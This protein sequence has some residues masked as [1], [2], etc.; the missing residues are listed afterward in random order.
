MS[1]GIRC[2]DAGAEIRKLAED[3]LSKRGFFSLPSPHHPSSDVE[4]VS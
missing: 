2:V 3:M 4:I 1:M